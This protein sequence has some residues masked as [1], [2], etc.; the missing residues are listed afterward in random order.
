[1]VAGGFRG[2]PSRLWTWDKPGLFLGG[3]GGG[4]LGYGPAAS[5]GASLP[6]RGTGK[7]CVNLQRD[8]EMLYTSSALWTAANTGV[9]LLTVMTNNRVYYNDVEHQEKVAITRGRPVENKLVG[10]E[11]AK[12]PVDFANLARSFSIHGE[13]PIIEQEQ[14]RPAVERAIKVIKEEK[15]PALVDVYMQHV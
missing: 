1:L 3:Y 8:G 7:I 9:P 13:G 5:V 2:W 15:R 10:M 4:G 12:P 6:Y 11:M 14:I